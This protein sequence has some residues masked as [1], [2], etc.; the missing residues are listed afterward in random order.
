MISRALLKGNLRHSIKLSIGTKLLIFFLLLSV[1]SFVIVG[2]IALVN[3]DRIGTFAQESSN[4]LGDS[5]ARDSTL[6]LENMGEATIKQKAEDIAL[7]LEIYIKAH[8]DKTILELQND[9]IFRSI[10]VQSVGQTGYTVV[11]DINSG[12]YYFHKAAV[13]ENRKAEDLF[14]NPASEYYNPQVWNLIKQMIAII[15]YFLKICF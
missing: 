15:C 3:M 10:T 12:T 4:I 14:S 7:Q 1:I 11:L 8:N 6:L 5:A 9:S 2:I 13:F